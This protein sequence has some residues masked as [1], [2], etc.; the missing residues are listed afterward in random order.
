MIKRKKGIKKWKKRFLIILTSLFFVI[1]ILGL[2]FNQFVY[3]VIFQFGYSEVYKGNNEKGNNIMDYAIANLN[4]PSSE[5]FHAFSIQNT[6]NGNYDIAIKALERAYQINPKEE[7]AYYGWVLLYYYHDYKKA[8]NILNTYDDYTPNFSDWPMGECIHY[9][10][11]LSYMQLKK[12]K[13]A[14]KE[15]D[16]SINNTSIEHGED[17]VNFMVFLNKGISLY[18]IGE[19]EEAIIQ[20]QNTIQNYDK[21]SEAYFFIAKSQLK[22]NQKDTACENL[23]IAHKLIEEGFKSSDTYV[24]LFNEIYDQQVQESIK[25]ECNK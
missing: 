13:D 6:K 10:K 5:I 17:W 15:F 1:V 4:K 8:L 7:G 23:N 24:E 14:I 18:N 9:L 12:Y 19:Y 21:C 16:I 22:L 25:K 11:G 2:I 3:L 20:L